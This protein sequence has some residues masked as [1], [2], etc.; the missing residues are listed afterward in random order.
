MEVRN[1]LCALNFFFSGPTEKVMS[2]SRWDVRA[3]M[4][5]FRCCFCMVSSYSKRT[6]DWKI[7]GDCLVGD[8]FV[9]VGEMDG[10]IS[11]SLIAVDHC[12]DARESREKNPKEHVLLHF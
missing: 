8:D 5:L 7:S 3:S 6:F 9:S 1:I 4:R 12:G 2:V 11:P 10:V